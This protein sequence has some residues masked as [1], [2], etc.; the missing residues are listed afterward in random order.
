MARFY[1]RV[2]SNLLPIRRLLLTH[3]KLAIDLF[4]RPDGQHDSRGIGFG[5]RR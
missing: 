1:K 2:I 3:Q 5:G 4:L